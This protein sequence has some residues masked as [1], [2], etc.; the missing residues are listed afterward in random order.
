MKPEKIRKYIDGF[1]KGIEIRKKYIEMLQEK[2]KH[3]ET[4]TVD[5][6]P[7]VGM[8]IKAQKC[9]YCDKIVSTELDQIK[10]YE[11]KRQKNK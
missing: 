2:C 4:E 1:I 3:E 7:R 6:F 5:S 11:S 8:L 9:K 10:Y